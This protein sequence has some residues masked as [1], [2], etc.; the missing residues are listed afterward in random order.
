[1]NFAERVLSAIHHEEPDRVPV[2]GLI[3]DPA[4]VNQ[5][6]GR[7]PVD[8][9]GM[10][11]NPE[12]RAGIRQ[13]LDSEGFW[14][15]TYY[16]NFSGALEA[17]IQIGFDANWC[18][19]AFM[20]LEDDPD[21]ELGLVWHDAFGRVW[22]MGS[23]ARGNMTIGY[24]RGILETEA[25]WDAWVERKAPLF[26]RVIENARAFHVH[27]HGVTQYPGIELVGTDGIALVPHR[28]QIAL[29]LHRIHPGILGVAGAR[30]LERALDERR[31]LKS[32]YRLGGRGCV[33]RHVPARMHM[34]LPFAAGDGGGQGLDP[35]A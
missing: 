6:L 11:R 27:R 20:Q 9:V 2:M 31:I 1:M 14:D 4:T 8:L 16:A 10:L 28:I 32:E 19:Y 17:A 13:L 22:E 18:I 23:D 12:R 7:E 26:E 24:T 35:I 33:D 21:T 29:Y 25:Q 15:R 30:P 3:M 5:I 34:G